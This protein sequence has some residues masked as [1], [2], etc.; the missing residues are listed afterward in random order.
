MSIWYGVDPLAEE[1]PGRSPYEYTFSNPINLVDPDGMAPE[2]PKPGFWK[3]FFASAG[4]GIVAVGRHI[5]N[6][7]NHAG[8]GF[9][10][11][12]KAPKVSDFCSLSN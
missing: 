4:R 5:I 1:F 2:D 10:P 8:Y 6:N 9:S 3:S 11:N 12:M 7:P